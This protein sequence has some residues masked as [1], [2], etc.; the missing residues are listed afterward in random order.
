MNG[1]GYVVCMTPLSISI[2]KSDVFTTEGPDDEVYLSLEGVTQ[3]ITYLVGRNGSG[4]SRTARAIAKASPNSLY[5][6]T[7]RLLGVMNVSGSGYGSSITE[8]QGIP[9]IEEALSDFKRSRS[10][11]LGLA[12][13]QIVVL[14]DQPEVGLRVAAFIRRSLGRSVE[15]RERAGL[16]DPYV[17]IEDRSYSLFRDEGHGLRELIVLLTAI[18]R[19]DWSLLVIDEPE[20]HLHPSLARLI[21]TELV[22]VCKASGRSSVLVTH[23]PSIIR[24]TDLDELAAVWHF[25]E[26]NRP[27]SIST[28]IEPGFEK[29]VNA[30]LKHNPALVSQLI[31]APRPVLV[32]G[33]NDVAS[34]TSALEAEF[35][36]SVVA[37]TELV[38]CGGSGQV[39]L[40]LSIADK[41]NLDA[42][43][44]GDFD[45]LLDSDVQRRMDEMPGVTK[46]YSEELYVASSKRAV[47]Q[48]LIAADQAKVEKN[49]PKRAKWL[50]SVGTSVPELNAKMNKLLAIW[51]DAGL[52]LHPEGMIEDVLGGSKG[53]VDYS[54]AGATVEAIRPVARWAAF[55]LDPAG[56]LFTLL[57]IQVE[58][59][60]S[61]INLLMADN[62]GLKLT[63]IPDST[64]DTQLVAVAPAS[65]GHHRLTVKR[66]IEYAGYWVEFG[67]DTPPRD[68]RLRP[69]TP[70]AA[71]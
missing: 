27:R 40:W 45:A 23:E 36:A 10:I 46:R 61:R 68:L 52:W 37:Q 38:P 69:P 22:N 6:S 70:A 43:A 51:R 16:L 28:V 33:V 19:E 15:L 7:D 1:I 41:L 55:T 66:P 56:D 20:L 57:H 65:E 8:F 54:A 4:K 2:L 3:P 35:D 31:F 63:S 62:P 59:I 29:R 67:R 42:R 5:L 9:L 30:S 14:R 44:I 47:S 13:E 32:E 49:A 39:A 21:V 25:S 18:Y 71:T 58:R 11:G 53:S 17:R 24:P 12:T 26:G 34:L 50:R 64:A 60:A 48:L